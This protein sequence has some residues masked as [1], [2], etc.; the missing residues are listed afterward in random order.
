MVAAFMHCVA[1]SKNLDK[2]KYAQKFPNPKLKSNC[3]LTKCFSKGC[4]SS[5][6]EKDWI[7]S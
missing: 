4:T 3:T 2:V 7:V 5:F 1:F 6:D